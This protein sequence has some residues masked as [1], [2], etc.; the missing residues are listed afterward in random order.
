[1]PTPDKPSLDYSYTAFQE[2]QGDNSFPGTFLDNDLA[3][4]K[5][6][7]DE[8][9]DFTS[10]V[11]RSDGKLQNGIVTQANLSSELQ[12]GVRPP[13]PWL[14]GTAYA[15]NDT[16]TTENGLYACLEAH[17]S[18][19]FANDLAAGIWQLL[20]EL[21]S[22]ATPADGSITTPKLADGGVTGPKIGSGAVTRD[23]L[24][25]SV[26][27]LFVGAELDCS[28]PFA[29]SGWVFKAGQAL[30]RAVY[31]ELFAFLTA[32]VTAAV[33]SGSPTVTGVPVDLRSIGLVGAPIEGPG[34]PSGATVV[35]FTINTITLS[36]NATASNASAQIRIFPHGNGDGSTTFTLPDD[37]DRANIG[38]GDMGGTAANRVTAS[39]GGNPGLLTT[40]LGA[41][42]GV[43][44]HT[45][46]DVEVPVLYG[47]TVSNGGHTHPY[48]DSTSA[49]TVNVLTDPGG[50]PILQGATAVDRTTGG[51]GAHTHAVTVNPAGGGA[52]PNVQPSRVT[53]KIIY[54]GV[55]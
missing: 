47:D 16:V 21:T 23:K 34:I 30:S 5:Q 9:I 38:R 7:I 50:A 24:A 12:I 10:N 13:T 43:D 19:V 4:L 37:R 14:T 39:G 44:R 41:A 42:G 55:F 52:H 40:R 54:T 1:M 18:N 31:S 22:L 2:G 32:T 8:T 51:A 46:A 11:V 49:T 28:G 27:L 25:A 45:L 15:A 36:A 48:V 33:S 6:A 53:N 35:S 20:F 3:N 17:T 26:P 29:P